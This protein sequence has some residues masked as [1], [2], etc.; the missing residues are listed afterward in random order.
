LLKRTPPALLIASAMG[1]GCAHGDRQCFDRR[2]QRGRIGK[3]FLAEHFVQQ[4]R[5]GAGNADAAL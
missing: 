2:R 3:L 1:A 5:F 4:G